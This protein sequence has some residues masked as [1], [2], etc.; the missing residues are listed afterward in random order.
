MDILLL[1]STHDYP[2]EISVPDESNLTLR[3]KE[4]HYIYIN[5]FRMDRKLSEILY[6]LQFNQ[7]FIFVRTINSAKWLDNL[8]EDSCLSSSIQSGLAQEQRVL[9]H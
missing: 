1:I 7:V 8:L 4:Q 9:A 6:T 3:S 2:I 5:A